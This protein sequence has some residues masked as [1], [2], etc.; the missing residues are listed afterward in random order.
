MEPVLAEVEARCPRGSVSKEA[1]SA[2]RSER[3][4]AAMS[5]ISQDDFE[6]VDLRERHTT[7]SV[8]GSMMK[9]VDQATGGIGIGHRICVP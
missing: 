4:A 7:R 2:I 3:D 5:E 1:A 6:R 9:M 8:A